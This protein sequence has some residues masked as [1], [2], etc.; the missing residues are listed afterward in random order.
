MNEDKYWTKL[1]EFKLKIVPESN[2][3]ESTNLVIIP[4]FTDEKACRKND[5]C[6]VS[7]D[8]HHIP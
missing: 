1:T 8:Y 7:I 3:S 5:K 2:Q 6:A 4:Y